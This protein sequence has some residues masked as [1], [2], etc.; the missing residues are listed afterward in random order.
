MKVETSNAN[1]VAAAVLA[2]SLIAIAGAFQPANRSIE[3]HREMDILMPSAHPLGI[4]RGHHLPLPDGAG[5]GPMGPN[6]DQI[7]PDD[8][9]AP[10]PGDKT[11]QP[12][13]T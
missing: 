13:P 11:N 1:L 3:T 8:D 10:D 6:D 4:L 7:D 9:D 5:P 12:T 2:A